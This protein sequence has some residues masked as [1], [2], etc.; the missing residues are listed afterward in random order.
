MADARRRRARVLLGSAPTT[1]MTAWGRSIPTPST[2]LRTP[3]RRS[4]QDAHLPSL[5]CLAFVLLAPQLSPS[6]F[7]SCPPEVALPE[8]AREAE[9]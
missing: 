6:L 1:V 8:V 5:R 2:R 3:P 4:A 9:R 7:S